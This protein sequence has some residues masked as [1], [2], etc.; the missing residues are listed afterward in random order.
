MKDTK[1]AVIHYI[2]HRI[3]AKSVFDVHSPFM[4]KLY[5]EVLNDYTHY[6]EYDKVEAIRRHL[7]REPGYI[8]KSDFGARSTEFP[9]AKQFIH[10]RSI[11]KS[12]AISRKHGQLL[13]RIARYFKPE[14]CL[15]LGTSLGISTLYLALGCP[16]MK[17]I[18]IE[19]CPNTAGVAR[20]NFDVAHVPNIRLMVGDFDTLVPSVVS[21]QKP[22]LVFIDG[23]HR[24]E[25]TLRYFEILLQH[26]SSDSVFI[27]DDIHWS[28][29]MSEA[30][31]EIRKNPAVKAT[32]DL[33]RMGLVFFKD[34][35]SKEDF[36]LRY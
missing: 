24:K 6:K 20:R 18:T 32:V 33:F 25:P 23:N 17:T 10:I 8:T 29:E 36:V 15:E 7:I 35:L 26:V 16:Q 11:V 5:T 21:E 1:G 31:D 27:F 14:C 3:K 22:L 9:W 12:S 19:G 28:M 4:Y 13:F 2:K 34:G 30:W